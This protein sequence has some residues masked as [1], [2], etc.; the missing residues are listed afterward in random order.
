M[1]KKVTE[2]PVR[3]MKMRIHDKKATNVLSIASLLVFSL[4]LNQWLVQAPRHIMEADHASVGKR[5]IASV[6]TTEDL[7]T[8]VNWEQELAQQMSDEKNDQAAYFAI[9]PNLRDELVFGVLQ[10]K[11][12]MQLQEGLIQSLE[13]INSQDE[14]LSADNANL[15]LVISNKADFLQQYKD[16]FSIAF[17]EVSKST[18]TGNKETYHLI[19]K[20]KT[21]VGAADFVLDNEGR[22][23]SIK[24]SR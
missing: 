19:N 15:P 16:I 6:P 10:G 12:G 4:F 5:G 22:V 9:K 3:N 2:L 17:S 14:A 8:V 13:F 24:V 18:E 1:E 23:L 11:Y 21:I 7:S 20:D